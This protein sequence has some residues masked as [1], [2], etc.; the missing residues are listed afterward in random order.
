M[1]DGHAT[2]ALVVI[3]HPDV[4]I[5]VLDLYFCEGCKTFLL[6]LYYYLYICFMLEGINN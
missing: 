3:L 1:S 4:L 2:M 5:R 6:F